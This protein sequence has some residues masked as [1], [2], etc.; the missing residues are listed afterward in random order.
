MKNHSLSCSVLGACL[1]VNSAA[2]AATTVVYDF[3]SETRY[4]V[5][6]NA[7]VGWSQNKANPFD[8]D[9][10]P[11]PYA[12]LDLTGFSGGATKT[13]QL[14]SFVA[15]TPDKS[16]VTVSGVLDFTGVDLAAPQAT[17]N[18]AILD[19]VADDAG[20]PT[21]DSFD[22]SLANTG[23]ASLAGISFTPNAGDSL[24]WDLGFSV[25]GASATTIGIAV[26]SVLRNSGY[27]FRVDFDDDNTRFYYGAA[28]TGA[29]VF[30]GFG[31]AVAT[32][33]MASIEM[34]H[35]P[36]AAAAAGTSSNMLA[37]DNIVVSIPEP[38]SLLLGLLG[39]S[40]LLRR[41]RA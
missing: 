27:Q 36:N 7:V 34:T 40:F 28:V 22:V 4:D 39:S 12:Y 19:P 32:G 11:A 21:R 37:F 18:L 6:S 8:V 23:G 20:F 9:G 14:G 25:N 3:Q 33:G 31:P 5:F 10:N 2:F 29:N 15:N 38:S 16:T 24:K 30:I 26:P 35:T 13:G 1:A 17:M 41:R